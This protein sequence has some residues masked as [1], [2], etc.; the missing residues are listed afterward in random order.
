MIDGIPVTGPSIF[1]K[2]ALLF[3][4]VKDDGKRMNMMV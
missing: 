4:T 3:D 1:S 2:R